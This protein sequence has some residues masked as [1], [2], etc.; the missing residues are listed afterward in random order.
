MGIISNNSK[1]LDKDEVYSAL[2]NVGAKVTSQRALILRIIRQ[3]QGH[4]D[5]DEILRQSKI[6]QPRISLSTVYR[7][8][9]TLKNLGLVDEV[10]ID[11]LHHHYEA[12]SSDEHY[13][14]V[15]LECGQVIEFEI[16]LIKQIKKAISDIGDF[17]L[18]DTELIAT[19]YCSE[20]MKL[21]RHDSDKS[22]ERTNH[23]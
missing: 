11:D 2:S 9:R 1:K 17:K 12:K 10:H 16:P 14:L 20:C 22:P 4:L 19:G 3:A 7:T 13:H 15:C 6:S 5:A 18:I 23:D 8:L 21:K